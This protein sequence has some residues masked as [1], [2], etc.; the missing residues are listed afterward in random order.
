MRIPS[1]MLI[2]TLLGSASFAGPARPVDW[3]DLGNNL[4][5]QKNPYYGLTADEARLVGVLVHTAEMREAGKALSPHVLQGE[6]IAL[7]AL[8]SV[9]IDG[10][11]KVTDVAAFGK[12]MDSSRNDLN[13]RLLGQSIE[14]SGFVLPLNFTDTKITEFVLVPFAGACV[15][16][17]PPSRNQMIVVNYPEG[18][19]VNGLF[20][21]VAISGQLVRGDTVRSIGFSD[22]ISSLDIGYQMEAVFVDPL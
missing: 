10:A 4:S 17:P 6:K 15:H 7:S 19:L 9:G 11:A 16:T 20:Q 22:G 3:S 1:I 12:M 8:N 14:I 21:A 2:L 5:S 18:F 13:N